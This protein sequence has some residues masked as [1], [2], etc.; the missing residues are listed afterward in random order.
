MKL[1]LDSA[2]IK[3]IEELGPNKYVYGRSR[4]V[5][6][7]ADRNVWVPDHRFEGIDC[8]MGH[9][10]RKA[11]AAKRNLPR[12]FRSKRRI[13]NVKIKN[14]DDYRGDPSR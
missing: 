2:N 9:R 14:K 8:G 4:T 1:F 10:R 13:R 5:H 12:K 3:E 7:C 6:R 11:V